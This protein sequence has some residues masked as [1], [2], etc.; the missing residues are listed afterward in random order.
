[1]EKEIEHKLIGTQVKYGY[2]W[3]KKGRENETYKKVFP[4]GEF[5]L[6]LEG[7]KLTKQVD[8]DWGRVSIG[9]IMQELF[10][11]DDIIIISKQPNGTVKVRKKGSKVEEPPKPIGIPLVAKLK[12]T[13]RNSGNPTLFEQVLV[14]SFCAL[15]FSAKH[16]GGQ[17]EP[18][19]LIGGDFNIILDSK[20]TKEGV[21]SERYINFDAMDR[22]KE[23]YGAT[24]VG[25]VAPGFSDGYVKE[26]AQGRGIVLIETAA[27]CE[28]LQNHATYPYEPDRIVEALFRP[29]KVV[30]TSK[31]IPPST[32]D[33]ERLIEL[34]AK[35]LS[36]MKLTQ[37]T[38]CSSEGLSHAYEWQGLDYSAD[39]IENALRFLSVVPLA[40]LQKENDKYCLT[41]SI[42]STLKKI[43][44]L[45][46]AFS[47]I[48]R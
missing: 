33:Q 28:L 29:G 11:Q 42:E 25:I 30:V 45:L 20:T 48:A 14:E 46:Q 13:Q 4:E 41:G 7:K 19:I 18:D 22:Y 21:I 23:K 17:S 5:T 38:S 36:D 2:I 40:I 47:R 9:K 27:I 8:W 6:D 12:E 35:I 10:I 44:L 32:V 1:M 26:T 24:H 37:K 31:D 3:W 34:V 16:I 15:G 39:D 43:G